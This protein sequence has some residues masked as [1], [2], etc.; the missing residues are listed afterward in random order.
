MIKEYEPVEAFEALLG[1]LSRHVKVM[2]F[3]DV[4]F[5]FPA[6][7]QKQ[8]SHP[9]NS[10]INEEKFRSCLER[11]GWDLEKY[12]PQDDANVDDNPL[13]IIRRKPGPE[14]DRID[15]ENREAADRL[16]PPIHP[17][18]QS[19]GSASSDLSIDIHFPRGAFSYSV[20]WIYVDFSVGG[21]CH[22][23]KV[24]YVFNPHFDLPDI[25]LGLMFA[26]APQG[27]TIDE[28]GNL[29]DI[30]ILNASGNNVR[31]IIKDY[32]Y[33]E[34]GADTCD[35]EP[36]YPQT[37]VDIEIGGRQLIDLF[38]EAFT[39]F[40]EN[41]FD[42]KRWRDTNVKDYYY[43]RVKKYYAK[44]SRFGRRLGRSRRS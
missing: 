16:L 34:G 29:K 25:F 30:D 33:G 28:E 18:V 38:L 27:I 13:I 35:D 44:F 24:S 22:T 1:S 20:G 43:E 2:R 17:L 15:R 9:G 26:H 39:D 23:V 19:P 21:I 11:N 42:M 36:G 40:L 41:E 37:Y 14:K 8:E 6:E 12:P 5:V 32:D 7:G 10:A 4:A 3:L 31:L